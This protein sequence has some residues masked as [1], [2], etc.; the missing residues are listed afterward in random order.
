MDTPSRIV[1]LSAQ[2]TLN[3]LVPPGCVHSGEI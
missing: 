1:V 3:A 2:E